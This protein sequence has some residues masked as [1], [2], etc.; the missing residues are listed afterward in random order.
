MVQAAKLLFQ[1]LH[2]LHKFRMHSF[3]LVVLDSLLVFADKLVFVVQN[4]LE[5]I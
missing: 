1:A 3:T 4:F 2:L 5:V